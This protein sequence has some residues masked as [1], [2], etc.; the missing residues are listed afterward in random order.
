[1]NELTWATCFVMA[2]ARNKTVNRTVR[3]SV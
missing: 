2:K 1:V 3:P